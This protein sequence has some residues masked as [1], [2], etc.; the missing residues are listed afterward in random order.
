MD[1]YCNVDEGHG[2]EV[3]RL[4]ARD[5]DPQVKSTNRTKLIH[6]LEPTPETLSG[7]YKQRLA[8]WEKTVKDH[9]RVT[10]KTI[11]DEYKLAVLQHKISP[12]EMRKHLALNSTKF[13]KY[14]EE[15]DRNAKHQTH[16]IATMR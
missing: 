11:D 15:K 10:K 6:I 3:Y 5:C 13:E 12:A 16:I 7:S 1:T 9:E 8:K 14:Q 2:L 4:L